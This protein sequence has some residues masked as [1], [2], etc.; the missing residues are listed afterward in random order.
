MA[1]FREFL[2]KIETWSANDYASSLMVTFNVDRY[3]LNHSNRKK[4]FYCV[5]SKFK[6]ADVRILERRPIWLTH[7]VNAKNSLRIC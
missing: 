1:Y 4:H 2:V 3:L 5:L 7:E 6:Q